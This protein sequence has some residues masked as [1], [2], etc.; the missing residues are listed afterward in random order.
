MPNTVIGKFS[1]KC[2]DS[3]VFNNNDMKLNKQLFENLFASEEYKR[4]MQNR[5][6]IGYLGHPEDPNCMEFEH[7]CIVMTDCQLDDNGEVS[8]DFDLISTPVGNVVKAFVDAGVKFGIS[9]RGAGDIDGQGN[10]D[11]DT[12]IF[13]GFDLVTFPAYH[14]CIPEFKEI[15]AS[16]DLNKQVKYKK[17]CAAINNNLKAITSCEALEVIKDQFNEGTDEFNLISDRIDE[18]TTPFTDDDNIRPDDCKLLKEKV[19]SLTKLYIE[20]LNELN[21]YKKI[22]EEAQIA[23]IQTETM[24]SRKIRS[25]KR[26]AASQVATLKEENNRAVNASN[27]LRK[28]VKLMRSSIIASDDKLNDLNL[29]YKRKIEAHSKAISQKDS[30]IESLKAKLRETVNASRQLEDRTSN[31]DDNVKSLKSRVE[32]AEKLVADYQQAYA[33]MYAN[34]LGVHLKDLSITASTNVD[35]LKNMI[36]SRTSTSNIMCNPNTDSDIDIE[37]IQDDD[38]NYGADLVTL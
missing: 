21:E 9:I 33:N 31:L 38:I 26:I 2:C 14:D 22:A 13:R 32:A 27:V 25:F 37:T 30:T 17:V 15:A 3:N 1:G 10:V 23:K 28:Q 20:T 29:K 19:D 4:A 35:D 7:A 36:C 18:L 11:P 5:H 34:A 8:G 12:F 16:S 24:C 6:Y